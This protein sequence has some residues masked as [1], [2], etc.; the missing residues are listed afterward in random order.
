M[1]RRL[2][3]DTLAALP[4]SIIRPAYDRSVITPGIVHIGLGAFHR[5]HQAVYVD[6]CLAAGETAW[7]IVGASLRSTDTRDALAPQDGLY[8]LA[9]RDGE[10]EDLRVVGSIISTLVAL[11]SPETLIDALVDPGIR[12]VTLT[13]TEKAY[14]RNATGNLDGTHPDVAWDLS[15]PDRPRTIYGFVVEA[16]ARRRAAG[17]WPF[18]VL[19]CDNL[20]ANGATLRRLLMEF[21]AKRDSGLAGHIA[22]E[23]AF[24]SSM[25]DRIVPATTDDDRTRI[26]ERLGVDDSWPVRTEPFCQWVIED[27]FPAGRPDWERFGVTMVDDVQPFED[28]KLRLLNGSHSAIAYLGLLSGHETVAE[29]FAEPIIRRFVE[30]LWEEAILTLPDDAGPDPQ[31]YIRKLSD[32][33]DNTALQHRTAQI[34]S[35]GSQKLPQ[36]I[37]AS[38]LDRANKG[39]PVTHLMLVVAAWIAAREA[40]G[41]QLTSG[42]FTD[43]LDG[44]LTEIAANKLSAS[45]TVRR[46][47]DAAGFAKDQP[48]REHLATVAAAHLESIR[49]RGVVSALSEIVKR[50]SVA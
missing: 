15:N 46:V 32:R 35:D 36:R 7:G 14:L 23:V 16:L 26:S 34:A 1:R 50:D 11:E 40:R 38:A 25:V 41:G 21:A 22:N 20:P 8:T 49:Q 12:I 2:S 42:L 44:P 33:Y 4:T 48:S 30:G 47:F 24:P 39:A 27:N 31:A 10:Q 37:V 29:A 28:M 3:N 45:K 9:V 5:A 43:P 18:T 6:D 19:S 17:T 13:V